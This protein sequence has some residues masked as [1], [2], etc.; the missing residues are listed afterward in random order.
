M[1]CTH[2][3]TFSAFTLAFVGVNPLAEQALLKKV[4]IVLKEECNGTAW[5]MNYHSLQRAPL[6]KE[7]NF[8]H[9]SNYIK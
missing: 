3:I 5:F 7:T 6:E 9:Q 4:F 1:A 8:I 2:V